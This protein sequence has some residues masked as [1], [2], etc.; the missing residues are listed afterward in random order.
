MKNQTDQKKTKGGCTKRRKTTSLQ[1]INER[2]IRNYTRKA[3]DVYK[4]LLRFGKDDD[5][6]RFEAMKCAKAHG[7]AVEVALTRYLEGGT[8]N[9]PTL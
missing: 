6:A 9:A 7:P 2:G 1:V 3:I 8:H 5:H 4:R